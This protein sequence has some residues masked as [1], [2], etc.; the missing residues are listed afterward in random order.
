MYDPAGNPRPPYLEAKALP[1]EPQVSECTEHKYKNHESRKKDIS[2]IDTMVL[3][4]LDKW[5]IG[6][7]YASPVPCRTQVYLKGKHWDMEWHASPGNNLMIRCTS[8]SRWLLL[9]VE[10][11]TLNLYVSREE[12]VKGEYMCYIILLFLKRPWLF[13]MNSAKQRYTDYWL[14]VSY[15]RSLVLPLLPTLRSH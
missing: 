4:K 3:S 7:V 12:I 13:S 8:P 15:E 11:R 14:E 5:A 6:W 2:K 10:W 9:L 1:I